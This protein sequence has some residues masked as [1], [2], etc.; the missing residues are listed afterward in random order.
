MELVEACFFVLEA[1]AKDAKMTDGNNLAF[2]DPLALA[3]I[4]FVSVTNDFQ[5][6]FSQELKEPLMT[7]IHLLPSR[8]PCQP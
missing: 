7:M 4:I 1:L 5:R 3:L 8:H 2:L 6:D